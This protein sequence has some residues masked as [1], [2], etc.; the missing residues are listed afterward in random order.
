MSSLEA[1]ILTETKDALGIAEDVIIFDSAVRMHINSALGTLNQL[2]IGPV[3]GFEIVDADAQWIDFVNTDVRLNPIKSYV[4]L[5]TKFLFDP[6]PNSWVSS[7]M[8]EQ[9]EE[10][11]W[12][13]NMVREGDIPLPEEEVIPEDTIFV[14]GGE[15]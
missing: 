8:K 7:A 15:I 3:G 9:I 14:D 6:P 13:L 1:S 5:R 4:F 11:E 10:L 2:G 12:R